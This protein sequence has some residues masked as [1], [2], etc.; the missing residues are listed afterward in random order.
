MAFFGFTAWAIAIQ[1]CAPLRHLDDESN[2]FM[3]A[4]R[5]TGLNLRSLRKPF[6][7]IANLYE[8]VRP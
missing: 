1:G 3:E 6:Q 4:N 5:D 8:G 2:S 7:I